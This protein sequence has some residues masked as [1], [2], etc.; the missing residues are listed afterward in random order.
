MQI[1]IWNRSYA[2]STV[3]QLLFVLGLFCEVWF[4]FHSSFNFHVFYGTIPKLSHFQDEDSERREV[5]YSD[6]QKVTKNNPKKFGESLN[7]KVAF[8]VEQKNLLSTRK[9]QF[10]ANFLFALW[11]EPVLPLG[12][13]WYIPALVIKLPLI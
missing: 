1:Q 7:Y 4:Y 13:R 10:F 2:N 9:T 3:R 8:K 6:N 5:E 11:K 12:G